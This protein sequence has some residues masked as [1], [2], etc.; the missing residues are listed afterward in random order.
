MKRKSK[1]GWAAMYEIITESG[2]DFLADG[3]FRIDK[4]SIYSDLGEGIKSVVSASKS[5][6]TVK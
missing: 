2:M 5:R 6:T 1:R 3:V 4:S